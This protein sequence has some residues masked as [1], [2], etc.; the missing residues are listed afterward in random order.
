MNTLEQAVRSKAA[1]NPKTRG[2]MGAE[3]ERL[4]QDCAAAINVWKDFLARPVNQ[5]DA[6]SIVAWVGP[7]R[8][9]QL[10]EI[11]LAARARLHAIAQLAGGEAARL[12]DYEEEPIEMAYRQLKPGETG[13]DAANVAVAKLTERARLFDRLRA[14]LGKAPVKG[15]PP[16][17]GKGAKAKQVVKARVAATKP[18]ATKKAS[19]KPQRKAPAKK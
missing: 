1:Q 8:A 11:N 14:D 19:A 13:V 6:W 7:A 10:H 12:M 3:L 5:G 16:A 4:S 2:A 17:A 18:K 9:K 15:A